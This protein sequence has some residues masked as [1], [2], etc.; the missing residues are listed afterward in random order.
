MMV[1]MT[2]AGPCVSLATDGDVSVQHVLIQL[3]MWPLFPQDKQDERFV[4]S[5]CYRAVCFLTISIIEQRT[6]KKLFTIAHF[7]ST[8]AKRLLLN[9]S[10]RSPQ[11]GRP[12]MLQTSLRIA[13]FIKPPGNNEKEQE[14]IT[15]ALHILSFAG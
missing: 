10:R 15:R 11:N 5:R 3:F 2:V 1:T 4:D 8:N 13:K 6:P 12:I 9:P 7:P 14:A